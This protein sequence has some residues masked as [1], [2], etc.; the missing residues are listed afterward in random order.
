MLGSLI[1]AALKGLTLISFAF[2]QIAFNLCVCQSFSLPLG[3]QLSHP[4]LYSWR[5]GLP[6][7]QSS[8]SVT[9]VE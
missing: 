1:L 7:A 2:H 8:G 5:L 9:P 4:W 6:N 3:R